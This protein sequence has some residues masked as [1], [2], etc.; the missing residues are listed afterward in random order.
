MKH[1]TALFFALSISVALLTSLPAAA[2]RE[3]VAK[4]VGMEVCNRIM[5][6]M[7]GNH[8]DSAYTQWVAGYISA[9]NLFG[10]KKQIE[11]IPDDAILDAYLQRYCK[12]NPLDKVIW[13]SMSLINELGGYRP[14]YMK[15]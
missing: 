7:K 2:Q 10:D 15:K 12:E 5:A 1:A 4:G 3:G 11:E 13:A 8:V 9:Y 6:N 14:P